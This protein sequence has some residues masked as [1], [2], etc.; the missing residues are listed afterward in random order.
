[1]R[2]VLGQ[3]L[4][5]EVAEGSVAYVVEQR[6]RQRVALVLRG[7]PLLGGQRRLPLAH[8]GE[9]ADEHVRRAERVREARVLG[10]WKHQRGEPELAH[11][12]QALHLAGR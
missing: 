8:V 3:D 4:L 10:P 1:M 9:Q 6:G 7:E 5:E 11:S 2:L 12:T